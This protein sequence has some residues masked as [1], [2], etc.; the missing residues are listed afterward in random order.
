MGKLGRI[1]WLIIGGAFVVLPFIGVKMLA[2]PWLKDAFPLW[3]ALV[4]VLILFISI[5]A[6]VGHKLCQRDDIPAD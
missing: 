3:G 6:S 2:E 4:M 1:K 5:L